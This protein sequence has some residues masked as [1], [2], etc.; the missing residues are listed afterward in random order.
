MDMLNNIELSAIFNSVPN[1]IFIKNEHLRFIFVNKAYEKMFNVKMKD[2][3]GKSVLDLEYLDEEHRIFYQNE[4]MEM[5]KHGKTRHHIFSYL[6]KE[7]EMHTCLYWSSGFIQK[8]GVR[9]LI[10]VIV[11]INKQSKKIHQ[12]RKKVRTIDSEKKEIAKKTKIDSLTRLHTR[13]DFD[14][15]LQN[16]TSSGN[17]F[18]CIMIDIDHFKNVNDT[19]G[20]I[21]GDSVLKSF[22]SVLKRCSRKRDMA[23]RYGG[24]EFVI[25]LPGSKLD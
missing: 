21:I 15:V 12:L 19:F 11:D 1:P 3:I 5:M 22:A 7:K 20:H 24:E 4:D 16:I 23:Y 14:E 17:V 9:G 6:Y 13:G 18:S 8:N 10:G 2:I 25:L